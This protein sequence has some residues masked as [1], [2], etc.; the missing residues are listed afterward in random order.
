VKDQPVLYVRAAY[1]GQEEPVIDVE[2]AKVDF[3]KKGKEAYVIRRLDTESPTS[4]RHC[5]IEVDENEAHERVIA[6]AVA[7]VAGMKF[8]RERK[9][10]VGAST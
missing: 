10:E 4:V 1:A 8:A 2:I 5:V 7:A 3:A 9:A 6:R